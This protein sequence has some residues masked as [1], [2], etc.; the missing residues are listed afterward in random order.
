LTACDGFTSAVARAVFRTQDY[1]RGNERKEKVKGEKKEGREREIRREIQEQS[2][3]NQP[4][5]Q[6][7]VPLFL[8]HVPCLL[9]SFG[10]GTDAESNSKRGS[11]RK[12]KG[13]KR[14]EERTC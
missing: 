9:Q 2:A 5:L 4:G 6:E 7:Q 11:E 14:K 8:L 13:D 3:P 12:G 10:Q 1:K